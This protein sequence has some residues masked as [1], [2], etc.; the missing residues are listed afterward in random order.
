[1]EIL[2]LGDR[3]RTDELLLKIPDSHFVEAGVNLDPQKL[4]KFQVVFDLNFDDNPGHLEYYSPKS[5]LVVFAGAVKKQLARTMGE[6]KGDINCALAGVN[7]LPSLINREIM[8][9]SLPGTEIH[10]QVVAILEKL[11]WN[12][13]IVEDRVGMVTPR[14][15]CMIINEAC[16]TVQ[17]GTASK[18]DI[19]LAMKL[20]TNYPYGPFEW[21]DKIGVKHVYE[22]LLAIHTDT[23]D[24]RYKICP[25]LKTHYLKKESFY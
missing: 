13:K 3:K 25:L 7:S 16:Y 1:M 10:N 21:A 12:Y 20:G 11:N 5:G 15:I 23:R 8:E 2:A 22:T 6:F 18:E 24:E 17:E 14:I 19:D 9:I 4:S